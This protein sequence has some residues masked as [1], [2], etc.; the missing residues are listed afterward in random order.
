MNA[1]REGYIQRLFKCSIFETNE[2][3]SIKLSIERLEKQELKGVLFGVHGNSK[4]ASSRHS[5]GG[6]ISRLLS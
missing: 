2:W 3:I 4:G 5:M 6:D 1:C